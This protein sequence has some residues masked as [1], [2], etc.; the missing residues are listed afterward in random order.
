LRQLALVSAFTALWGCGG[1]L[2]AGTDRLRGAL[3]VDDRSPVIVV[4]DGAR[5]NWHV[6]YAVVLAAAERIQLAGIVVNSSSI[7]PSVETNVTGFRQL[8]AAARTSGMRHLPDPLASIAPALMRPPSGII[9]DTTPNRSEGARFIIETSRRLATPVHRV[10]VATGGAVTDVADAYLMDPSVAER[11]V[12]VA[13]LG[14]S[15]PEGAVA[16][17]PNGDLDA[18]ATTIVTTR[19]R[20][21]QVNGFYD[22]QQ[23]LSEPRLAELPAHPFGAWMAAKRPEILDLIFAC[24]Q[25]SVMSVAFPWFAQG[26]ARMQPVLGPEHPQLVPDPNGNAWHFAA[27]DAATASAEFWRLLLD[28]QTYE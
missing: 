25:V 17:V 10:A 1:E 18:W 19:L 23:D 2:D 28:P 4:N 16:G 20:Y 26:V 24:D 11:I 6:E 8:V 15:S 14:S 9:E 12:V 21:V 7:Y 22:Q 13:S 3:P 5:D 27:S